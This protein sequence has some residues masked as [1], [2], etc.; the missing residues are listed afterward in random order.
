MLTNDYRSYLLRLWRT[1]EDGQ[2]W[3]ALL[4]E[5]GTGNRYG[6]ANLE[7]LIAFLQKLGEG[8]QEENQEM[9]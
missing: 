3:R 5:V 1:R 4:E 7:K 2:E 8:E 6:F 9:G